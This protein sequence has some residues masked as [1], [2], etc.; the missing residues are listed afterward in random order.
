VVLGSVSVVVDHYRPSGLRLEHV[1]DF[2]CTGDTEPAIDQHQ[3][4]Q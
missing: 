3:V 1:E 2:E 4:G